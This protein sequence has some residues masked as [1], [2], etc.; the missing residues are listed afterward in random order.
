[1]EVPW[2]VSCCFSHPVLVL[3]CLLLFEFEIAVGSLTS[4]RNNLS[5]P[6]IPESNISSYLDIGLWTKLKT[7]L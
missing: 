2:L 3:Y 6:T 5:Q 1:M 4:K 7:T